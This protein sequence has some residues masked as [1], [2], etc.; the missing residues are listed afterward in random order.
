MRQNARESRRLN[1]GFSGNPAENPSHFLRFWR[2]HPR[3]HRGNRRNF[4]PQNTGIRP[5][6]LVR[7]PVKKY[8]P[9]ASNVSQKR[10]STPIKKAKH[11]AKKSD[12]KQAPKQSALDAEL[13]EKV[14]AAHTHKLE[15]AAD[16]SSDNTIASEQKLA[17][18][19][20][21][22]KGNPMM[23]ARHYWTR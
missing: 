15:N 12:Q 3:P 22:K 4:R 1:A 23:R 13:K 11:E 6:S 2:P 16:G 7:A 20:Q 9:P 8:T 18:T 21:L 19:M 17:E 10:K 14:H 5:K